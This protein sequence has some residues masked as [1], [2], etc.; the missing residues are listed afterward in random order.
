MKFDRECEKLAEEKAKLRA[1][2][3]P[4]WDE[5]LRERDYM[6]MHLEKETLIN[7]IKYLWEKESQ[8]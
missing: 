7:Y 8:Q 2:D 3:F 4:E 6:L 5:R 1:S